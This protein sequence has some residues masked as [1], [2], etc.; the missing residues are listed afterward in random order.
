M[1][2]VGQTKRPLGVRLEEHKK[3]INKEPNKQN[4]LTKHTIQN[5]HFFDFDNAKILAN[6]S[7]YRKRLVLEMCHIAGNDDAVNLRTDLENLSKIYVPVIK[8][9]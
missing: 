1:A 9:V 8:N 2:N 3:N 7:H 4:A 5:D 6:E